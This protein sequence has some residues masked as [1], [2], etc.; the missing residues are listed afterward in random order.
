MKII[1]NETEPSSSHTLYC[2]VKLTHP[3]RIKGAPV[4]DPARFN[5]T[6][7]PGRRLA[8]RL[9]KATRT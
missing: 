1:L 2:K 7:V 4:S 3:L 6:T 9:R 8:L 5:A